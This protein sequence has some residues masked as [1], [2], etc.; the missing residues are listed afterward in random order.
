MLNGTNFKAWLENVLIILRVMDLDL[1]LQV[2]QPATLT[3][4]STSDD[5]REMEK[6]EPHKSNGHETCYSRSFSGHYVQ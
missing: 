6:S 4:K 3:D 1:A 5:K 2:D